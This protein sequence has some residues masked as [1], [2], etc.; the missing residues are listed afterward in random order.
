[1]RPPQHC[2]EQLCLHLLRKMNSKT[3]FV[4][5]L[6][7]LYG[8]ENLLKAGN[9]EKMENQMDNRPELGRVKN[10]QKMARKW[11][12]TGNFPRKS[13]CRPCFGHFY[14]CQA[15]GRFPLG[16]PFFP[17]S[18]FPTVVHSVQAQQD[19]EFR[20]YL[21]KLCYEMHYYFEDIFS[22]SVM[23]FGRPVPS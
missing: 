10:G 9:G 1:M 15:L 6:S 20:L 16:F 13:M 19:P 5:G 22:L 4:L 7:G 21:Y 3:V 12:K 2:K 11:T 14:P 18:G 8:M 23:P 17:D